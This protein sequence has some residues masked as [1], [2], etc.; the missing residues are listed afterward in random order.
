MMD[1]AGTSRG[2]GTRARSAGDC[3]GGAP[4]RSASPAPSANSTASTMAPKSA[5]RWRDARD[6]GDGPTRSLGRRSAATA[7][8]AC[9]PRSG[10]AIRGRRAARRVAEVDRPV[11]RDQPE[12]AGRAAVADR[13]HASAPAPRRVV[14]GR[15]GR[16]CSRAARPCA[17]AGAGRPRA[18]AG[19]RRW[20]GSASPRRRRRPARR[21]SSA[22]PWSRRARRVGR[23]R[24]AGR[25]PACAG[26]PVRLAR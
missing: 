13:T 2:S 9:P 1:S 4:L 12:A 6:A 19:P 5:V 23:A 24:A 25:A 20:P 14:A 8:A 15:S 18:R 3:H 17:R 22:H 26:R 16:A 7:A 21:G 10:S 11:P